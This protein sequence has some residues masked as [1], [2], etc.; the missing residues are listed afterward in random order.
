MQHLLSNLRW[1]YFKIF[2]EI[3]YNSDLRNA[4]FNSFLDIFTLGHN[5][6]EQIDI[7]LYLLVHIVLVYA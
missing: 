5:V 6:L 1:R 3:T 7:L 4:F 2:C